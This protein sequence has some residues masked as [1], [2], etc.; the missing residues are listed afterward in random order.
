MIAA[1]SIL[2]AALLIVRAWRAARRLEG[3]V[4]PA[5]HFLIFLL[6]TG[7]FQTGGF[8][9]GMNLSAWRLLLW[10]VLLVLVLANS[11]PAM[12][13]LTAA[14]LPLV[15]FGMF[16]LWCILRLI[17]APSV[18]FG[19]RNLLKVLY[20]FLVLLLARKA[21]RRG[22][23][24]IYLT[25]MIGAS[26]IISLFTS[27]LSEQVPYL[28]YN[29]LLY[30]VFWPRATFADHAAIMV[31][32]ILIVLWAYRDY[33]PV[34][35]RRIYAL[36]LIW[37]IASPL[38]VACRT[39]FLATVAAIA[40]YA[41]A[42]YRAKALPVMVGLFFAAATAFLLVPQVRAHMFRNPDE[43]DFSSI[44]TGRA[45]LANIDSSGR[46]AMWD[47]L[48][49][50]FYGTNPLMGSGLG[51]TQDYLYNASFSAAIKAAHSDYVALLC[52][53]GLI[54][55]SLYLAGAISALV[56]ATKYVWRGAT[57]E[58]RAAAALVLSSFPACLWAAGFDNVF[59]YA[60]PV[61]SL[62]FAF[63]GILLG[64]ISK[65]PCPAIENP[66]L[67]SREYIWSR[68]LPIRRPRFPSRP[69]LRPVWPNLYVG[70]PIRMR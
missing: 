13:R 46:F 62:P 8:D 44:L 2:V 40:G 16:L 39:G 48:L 14:D 56:V 66:W 11:E 59:N 6:M 34:L 41:L 54:G 38:V 24:G 23:L 35:L 57:M 63:T 70:R 33:L 26:L 21:A 5:E 65:A 25:P 9:F 43:V 53:T 27:G 42:R 10:T 68:L 47:D 29:P 3:G 37:L 32:V 22:H 30:S 1:I 52:D 69:P 45:S 7:M 61:H 28:V 36:G 20:P 17:D 19:V 18:S 55:L 60:L 58:L 50:R 31:G 49:D 64:M 4:L 15:F 51:V 67:W 12:P